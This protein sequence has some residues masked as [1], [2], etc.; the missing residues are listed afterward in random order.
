MTQTGSCIP[1]S[2]RAGVLGIYF[3]NRLVM[4]VPDLSQVR[5][6]HTSFGLEAAGRGSS[7]DLTVPEQGA[8]CLVLVEGQRKRLHHLSLAAFKDDMP[9]FPARLKQRAVEMPDPPPGFA[10][11]GLGGRS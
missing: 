8:P 3:V 2:R 6:F 10:S 7:L 9:R 1:P 11:S 5:T 4:A